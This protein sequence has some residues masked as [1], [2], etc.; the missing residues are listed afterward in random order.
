MK[1]V[2]YDR[3][4][5]RR[6]GAWVAGGVIDLPDAVGHPA[7]PT[8]LEALV[9]HS[10]GT[11]LDAAREALSHE[12]SARECLVPRARLLVPLLPASLRGFQAFAGRDHRSAAG[13][14]GG[15]DA[16]TAT[17]VYYKG[18]HRSVLGPDEDLVRPSFT[19]ELDYELGIGCVVGR[20]GRDLAPAD[21]LDTIFGYTLLNDW[22]ARDVERDELAT[23][24]GP[25]KSRDFA[26]SLGPCV[27]TADE[28]DPASL[29]M[30][31]RVD[32]Q[33]WSEGN[34]RDASWT[35]P[36]MIAHVSAGEDVLPGDVYDSGTFAGGCAAD[37]GRRI[38]PGQV[39]EL[40]ADGIGVLR[41]CVRRSRPALRSRTR[42]VAGSTA[43]LA[44]L[45]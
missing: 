45:Q 39:V 30:T 5:A 17:P 9:A 29:R 4:G 36:E 7:F 40:E 32:G 38:E 31:A 43:N 35:F 14:G 44:L 13:G 6:L 41:T 28:V 23:G 20:A 25:A 34:L 15:V 8:T 11:T 26:T 12:E 24:M 22:T 33:V 21:A 42:R 2:T 10:G 27:V 37:L 16:W 1:L 3:A 19:H 18:N